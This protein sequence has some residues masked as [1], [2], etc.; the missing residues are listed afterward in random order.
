VNY[1]GSVEA[2]CA[3]IVLTR[4]ESMHIR[5][6]LDS[7]RGL[8]HE[9]FVVDS[10]ST[11]ETCS[12]AREY[13]EHVRVHEF[14]DQAQQFNWA[15]DNLAIRSSWILRLDADEFLLPELRDEISRTLAEDTGEVRAFAMKR[16]V[17]FRGRWI[18][19][20][21]MYPQ[22]LI[23]LFRAGCARSEQREMDEHIVV[24]QGQIGRLEHDFVDM[25]LRDLRF[26]TLKHEQYATRESRMRRRSSS[27]HSTGQLPRET[28]RKRWLRLAVYENSPLFWRAAAFF[29]YRY[30]V[31][32]GFLDG[33]EGLVFHTLQGF[34]YRFYIDAKI[35]E[36]QSIAASRD[37]IEGKG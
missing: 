33:R 23:R 34:W 37:A 15:L 17:Y 10:G 2:S 8:A 25:N 6:C 28:A 9:V 36:A 21:G 26:F 7:V 32:L 19:H 1:R 35:W 29:L 3:V 18:R 22:W 20:G 11:D 4:D 13:T 16:R 5:R 31:R 27:A 12:I 14:T 24:T 30:V